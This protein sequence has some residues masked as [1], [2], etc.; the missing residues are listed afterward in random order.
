M[1]NELRHHHSFPFAMI[2]DFLHPILQQLPLPF[3]P[4]LRR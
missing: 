3:I 4:Q 2:A 1:M